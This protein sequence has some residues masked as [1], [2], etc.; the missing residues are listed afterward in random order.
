[1]RS[2]WRTCA[3]REQTS[4]TEG[5]A[6]TPRVLPAISLTAG[7]HYC[8]GLA[9]VSTRR[10]RWMQETARFGRISRV[11]KSTANRQCGA[12][13][14]GDSPYGLQASSWVT[15]PSVCDHSPA[16]WGPLSLPDNLRSDI[17]LAS[18]SGAPYKPRHYA[19]HNPWLQRDRK[20]THLLSFP[21]TESARPSI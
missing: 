1:M 4:L 5:V 8:Y 12:R 11:G 2:R 10:R 17:S 19:K 13:L 18:L 15:W 20:P 3:T 16:P 14:S 9:M 7:R 21:H 6:D